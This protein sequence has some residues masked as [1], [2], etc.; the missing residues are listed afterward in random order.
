MIKKFLRKLFP[1]TVR[2]RY[3]QPFITHVRNTQKKRYHSCGAHTELYGPLRLVPEFIDLDDY[4]RLQPNV[5]VISSGGFFKVKKFSAIGSGCLIVPGNHVPT[6][7]VPQF[8]SRTH[9][10]DVYTTVVVKEDVWVGA[11]S[12]LLAH[13][14][15]GRGCVVA[16][17]S[18]VTKEIP[19][20]AVVAGTPAKVIA[21]RFSIEQILQHEAILYPA[22]ERLKKEYLEELFDTN[23]KGLRVLGTS[24][25]TAEEKERLDLCKLELGIP[26]YESIG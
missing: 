15:I 9:I 5:E 23:Y 13:A 7:G 4:T 2:A 24:K 14:H 8:L 10:N 16:A 22:E 1:D 20:Y 25:M 17:G 26:N 21:V 19:P 18:V 3:M 11:R 12:T 6:V